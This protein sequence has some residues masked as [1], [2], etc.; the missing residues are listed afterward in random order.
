MEGGVVQLQLLLLIKR[1]KQGENEHW[2]DQVPIAA[3][4]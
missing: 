3:C 2:P 4:C 1:A